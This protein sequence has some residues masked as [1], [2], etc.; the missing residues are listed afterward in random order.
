MAKLEKVVGKHEYDA[1]MNDKGLHTKIK[2][3][4]KDENT[5]GKFV[6]NLNISKWD[7]ETWINV[8]YPIAVT[9]ETETIQDDMILLRIGNVEFIF[10]TV[11]DTVLEQA[12]RF[13]TKPPNSITI[14]FTDSGNIEY[15]YQEP[16]PDGM[17]SA[18]DPDPL[19]GDCWRPENVRDSYAIY[20]T[21]W[22]HNKYRTGKFA[23][24]YRW[25]FTDDNG[26]KD[27]IKKQTITKTDATHGTLK[28]D[29]FPQFLNQATYP[30]TLMG[31]GDTWGHTSEGSSTYAIDSSC[32]IVG[33]L[34]TIS[35]GGAP[36]AITN[37]T[38]HA[39][40]CAFNANI[41]NRLV[42]YNSDGSDNPTSLVA[43]GSTD[44][45]TTDDNCAGGSGTY[46]HGITCSL[47]SGNQYHAGFTHNYQANK[48]SRIF[49]DSD[50][51]YDAHGDEAIAD[52]SS[53]PGTFQVDQERTGRRVSI[54]LD[55]T[56]GVAGQPTTKR[57]GGIPHTTNY[58]RW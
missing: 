35:G 42:I 53:P 34:A 18:P 16:N 45:T 5:G 43:L 13:Y 44:L 7:D 25:Q 29:F 36:A 49:Y 19:D 20:K 6:P 28:L 11:G 10:F 51:S 24:L 30:I 14:D 3:G 40:L 1:D 37:P 50:A 22:A 23:H 17:M 46:S 41:L 26:V 2:V 15:H 56:I 38:A 58:R 8:N 12:I 32:C 39:Y 57:F 21:G 54:Y 31:G 48:A 55:Y 52:Y 27:W 4:G 47:T 33:T 9:T